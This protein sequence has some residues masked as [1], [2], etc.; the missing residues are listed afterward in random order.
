[1]VPLSTRATVSRVRHN[2]SMKPMQDQLLRD[3]HVERT[4]LEDGRT[5]LLYSWP[6]RADAGDAPP[7][8]RDEPTL[9]PWSPEAGPAD[10]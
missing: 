6:V 1:M 3:M 5:L 2:R 7:Q 9:D 4:R 8:A 10:V